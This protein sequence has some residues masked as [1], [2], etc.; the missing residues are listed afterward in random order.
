MK[1]KHYRRK[2]EIIAD[3]LAINPEKP[4]GSSSWTKDRWDEALESL[5]SQQR[6]AEIDSIT[7]SLDQK[8]STDLL[9]HIWQFLGIRTSQVTL[10]TF[11]QLQSMYQNTMLPLV[12]VCKAFNRSISF[13]S[14][15]HFVGNL[16]PPFYTQFQDVID[17]AKSRQELYAI[18]NELQQ[19]L[20]MCYDRFPSYLRGHISQTAMRQHVSGKFAD[21]AVGTSGL[22]WHTYSWSGGRYARSGGAAMLDD[23]VWVLME[24][25]D[26]QE[27]AK[28]LC[29]Q[30][31]RQALQS[32]YPQLVFEMAQATPA[33]NN[34]LERRYPEVKKHVLKEV[35]SQIV[36][37]H[38]TKELRRLHT[39]GHSLLML[40]REVIRMDTNVDQDCIET[41]VDV[42]SLSFDQK[43]PSWSLKRVLETTP[44]IWKAQNS[45]YQKKLA[46]W[47]ELVD[48]LLSYLEV[49]ILSM[50]RCRPYQVSQS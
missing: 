30:V 10:R 17:Q 28:E 26:A 36:A 14:V 24:F 18:L 34:F 39:H 7:V 37:T 33:Y 50:L 13:E 47:T 22:S 40:I 29:T 19:R 1:R 49:R 4:R 44:E 41:I 31:L 48:Q 27:K 2:K 16:K 42:S 9:L 25:E 5:K 43:F 23:V 38:Y 12:C 46:E 11:G 6:R 32:E 20:Q 8:L 35:G 21:Y 3:F 15:R 45:K